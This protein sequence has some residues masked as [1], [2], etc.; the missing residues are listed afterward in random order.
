VTA[1]AEVKV[2]GDVLLEE[3]HPAN[4]QHLVVDVEEDVDKIITLQSITI[5]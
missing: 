1:V 2:E 4:H 3:E 5:L